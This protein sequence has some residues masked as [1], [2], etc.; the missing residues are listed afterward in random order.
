[1]PIILTHSD[2][3]MQINSKI[4]WSWKSS[5]PRSLRSLSNQLNPRA[6]PL[7]PSLQKRHSSINNNNSRLPLQMPLLQTMTRETLK[8]S[9]WLSSNKARKTMQLLHLIIALLPKLRPPKL[10]VDCHPTLCTCNRQ[11]WRHSIKITWTTR[12][13]L[14]QWPM[15]LQ[16]MKVHLQLGIRKSLRVWRKASITTMVK[17]VAGLRSS[18]RLSS[19]TTRI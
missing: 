15:E 10:L 3:L 5:Q 19:R 12:I 4:W 14:R 7:R 8:L 18:S 2:V 6:P 13:K 1:M 16:L 11:R 17:T 9:V